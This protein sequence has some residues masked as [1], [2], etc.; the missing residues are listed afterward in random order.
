MM[1]FANC[2]GIALD[3]IAAMTGVHGGV[4][5]LLRNINSKASFIPRSNHSL[6]LSGVYASS[7]SAI[8][9]FTVLEK[10]SGF[11]CVQR[12]VKEI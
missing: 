2:R 11:L 9:F 7:T 4:Q 8:S 10:Q 5:R 12:S 1:E 3:N 6:N